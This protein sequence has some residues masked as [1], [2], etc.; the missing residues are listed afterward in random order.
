MD[1]GIKGKTALVTGAKKSEH[2]Q[3][4]CTIH[5]RSLYGKKIQL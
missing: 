5:I 2:G 3:K 4:T 1:Y